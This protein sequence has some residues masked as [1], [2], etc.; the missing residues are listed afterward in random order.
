MYL[1][2]KY[3]ILYEHKNQWKILQVTEIS[4]MQNFHKYCFFFDFLNIRNQ[5]W[6]LM[7]I[8]YRTI[9][10]KLFPRKIRTVLYVHC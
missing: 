1:Y 7:V 5:K 10:I 2:Q 3:N 8:L 9:F 6:G 4:K